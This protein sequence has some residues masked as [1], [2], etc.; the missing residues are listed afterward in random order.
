MFNKNCEIFLI[1]HNILC[2]KPLNLEELRNG[3]NNLCSDEVTPVAWET[4]QI[5]K[6]QLDM[7]VSITGQSRSYIRKS[8][9]I[10]NYRKTKRREKSDTA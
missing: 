7:D 2:K 4:A 10:K 1:G 9:S 3:I 6:R 8:V 5:G